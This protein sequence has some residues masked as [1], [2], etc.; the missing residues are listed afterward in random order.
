M[1]FLKLATSLGICLI[2]ALPV[3]MKAQV[4][5]QVQDEKVQR[6]RVLRQLDESA[7]NFHSVAADSEFDT[8]QTDPVPDKDVQKGTVY[9]QREGKKLQM[10]AHINEHNGQPVNN[11][12]ILSGGFARLYEGATGKV[13]TSDKFSQYES[14][15]TVGFGASGKDLEDK[16]DIKYAGSEVLD[17]VKTEKLE[18]VAKDPAVRKTFQKVTVWMDTQR[19]VSLKQVMQEPGG[20]FRVAVYYKIKLNQPLPKTAFTLPVGAQSK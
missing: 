10:A 13:T 19:G 16:W 6:E 1:R 20:D 5:S 12:Y 11:M 17:G 2:F 18:L 9:Y 3:A 7:K 14:Y 4:P 15:F 8:N